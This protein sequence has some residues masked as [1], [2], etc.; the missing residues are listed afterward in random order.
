MDERAELPN[1]NPDFCL[2]VVKRGASV[3]V[4]LLV[5]AVIMLI[6][7]GPHNNRCPGWMIYSEAGSASSLRLL[8]GLCTA[9]P[10]IWFCYVVLRWRH[11]LQK[12]I[13]TMMGNRP[14]GLF[15]IKQ[16]P[17]LMFFVDSNKICVRMTIVFCLLGAF[18]LWMILANCTELPLQKWVDDFFRYV[19]EL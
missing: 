4:A 12:T 18:P 6:A 11:V 15:G 13:D 7:V 5:I 10:A 19:R 9:A 17:A 8:V 3:C 16:D 2:K 14:S 1:F